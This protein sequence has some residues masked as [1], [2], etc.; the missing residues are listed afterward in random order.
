MKISEFKKILE[1]VPN[2][3][4]ILPNGNFVPRHFHITEA[5]LLT[6]HFI[7]CGHAVRLQKSI[8]MQLWVADDYT[9]RLSPKTLLG[10]I[11]ASE[12]LFENEDLEIEIEFQSET[13]GK[14]GVAF[15]GENFLLTN[16]LTDCLAKDKCGVPD[17]KEKVVL[18]E[19]KNN[20]CCSPNS[21]CC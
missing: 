11:T 6:K 21:S 4:F 5:G 3:N 1:K 18:S 7:D 14:Y 20:T 12:N 13:I 15:K 8:T 16:T 9:H 17:K 10:I 2:V 19:I